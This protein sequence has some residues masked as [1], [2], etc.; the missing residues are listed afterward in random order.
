M[1]ILQRGSVVVDVSFSLI[2]TIENTSELPRRVGLYSEIVIAIGNEREVV[3]N[4][5]VVKLPK[6]AR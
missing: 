6:A 5:V 1:S 3:E 4:V 2:R